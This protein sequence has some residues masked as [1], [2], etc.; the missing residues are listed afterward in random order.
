MNWDPSIIT[1]TPL[2]GWGLVGAVLQSLMILAVVLPSFMAVAATVQP[3]ADLNIKLCGCTKPTRPV[4]QIGR[5]GGAIVGTLLMEVG[6]VLAFWMAV[7]MSIP[8]IGERN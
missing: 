3:V 8:L 2:S 6:I 4:G 7:I 1:A 5:I